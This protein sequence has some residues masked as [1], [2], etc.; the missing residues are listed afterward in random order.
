AQPWVR[1]LIAAYHSDDIAHFLLTRYADSV[2]R[3]W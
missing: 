3:P 2:R 1:T